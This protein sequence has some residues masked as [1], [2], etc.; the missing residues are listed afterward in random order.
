MSLS[1]PDHKI[2]VFDDKYL[3]KQNTKFILEEGINIIDENGFKIYSC[4]NELNK[5]E[6]YDNTEKT[7]L[8]N[9]RYNEMKYPI[10]KLTIYSGK[11]ETNVA[12]TIAMKYSFLSKKYF[13]EYVNKETNKT[14]MLEIKNDLSFTTVD[15]YAGK[16][17]E[18]APK[19]GTIIKQKG[20]RDKDFSIEVAANVD[21]LFMI[22]IGICQ[23][24][25]YLNS[26][27]STAM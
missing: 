11:T 23:Y 26:T 4:T 17:K 16:K 12:A 20:N 5:V 21:Q 6:V 2:S 7:V 8:F 25:L 24:K 14:E 27:H 13:I 18:G 15:I 22:A 9:V 10:D 3:S 19:I 1:P